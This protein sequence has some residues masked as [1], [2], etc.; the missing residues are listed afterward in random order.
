MTIQIIYLP[1][2]KLLIKLFNSAIVMVADTYIGWV[3]TAYLKEDKRVHF[4]QIILSSLSRASQLVT[5]K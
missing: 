4:R 5:F 2:N 3:G 1:F